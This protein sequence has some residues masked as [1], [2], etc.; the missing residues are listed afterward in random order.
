MQELV[1]IAN[2]MNNCMAYLE[3][4]DI[5]STTSNVE[6]TQLKE[7]Y[8]GIIEN[9]KS[10]YKEIIPMY[11][12]NVLQYAIKYCNKTRDQASRELKKAKLL[13]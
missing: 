7:E 6:L 8:L 2:N 10:K 12:N 1:A 3:G 4:K 9:I 11:Q 13:R 5:S